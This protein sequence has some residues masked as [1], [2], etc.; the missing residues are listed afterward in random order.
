MLVLGFLE[1]KYW[2][3]RSW[4]SID[5]RVRQALSFFAWVFLRG[6]DVRLPVTYQVRRLRDGRSLSA[7][8]VIAVQYVPNDAGKLNEQVI[9]SMIA[10]FS[11]M[12]GGLE[13]QNRCLN[14]QSP[15][16]Y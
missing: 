14:I 1:V 8:E 11:P 2:R 6:G 15:T 16:R 10:S 4:R 13:Y 5:L 9:F 7:R 12:E 3:R